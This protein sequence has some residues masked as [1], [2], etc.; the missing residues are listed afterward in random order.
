M[1]YLQ[2]YVTQ[3]LSGKCLALE[4]KGPLGSQD[5]PSR[6]RDLAGPANVVSFSK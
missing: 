5:T 1:I 3:L 6:F 2:G 4:I